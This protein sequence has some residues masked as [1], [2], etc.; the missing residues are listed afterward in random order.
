[1]VSAL[2]IQKILGLLGDVSEIVQAPCYC[3]G[4]RVE[5][6]VQ[7]KG[8]LMSAPGFTQLHEFH[9][10]DPKVVQASSYVQR[11]GLYLFLDHQ[12]RLVSSF[13]FEII[14][15]ELCDRSQVVQAHRHGQRVWR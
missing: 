3:Q 8:S 15:T 10:C 9:S 14:T 2:S 5:L 1:M 7:G 4:V 12:S 13:G 11:F 6:L